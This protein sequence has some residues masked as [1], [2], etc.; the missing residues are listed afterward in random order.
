[1]RICSECFK[2]IL[3]DDHN[4]LG[5]PERYY[6]WMLWKIRKEKNEK[7]CTD[8]TWSPWNRKN[9]NSFTDS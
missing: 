3:S 5:E 4:C 8:H 7:A 2:E 9:N 1:M 6:E